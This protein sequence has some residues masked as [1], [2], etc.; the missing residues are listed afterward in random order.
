M[1]SFMT[2]EIIQVY[3]TYLNLVICKKLL[4]QRSVSIIKPCMVQPNTKL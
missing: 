3:D 4:N 1:L 2:G